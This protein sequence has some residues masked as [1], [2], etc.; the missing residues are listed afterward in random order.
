MLNFE[1]KLF[2]KLSE[3]NKESTKYKDL[4]HIAI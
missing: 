1:G 4:I 2:W 3:N